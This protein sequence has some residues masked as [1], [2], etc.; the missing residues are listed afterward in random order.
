MGVFLDLCQ[1]PDFREVCTLLMGRGSLSYTSH[2]GATMSWQDFRSW[3][4]A[5]AR[6]LRSAPSQHE[7]LPNWPTRSRK[8][9][10]RVTR[11]RSAS[12]RRSGP[13]RFFSAASWAWCVSRSSAARWVRV[14]KPTFNNQERHIRTC[15]FP[16]VP[17]SLHRTR[18]PP[19]FGPS[20]RTPLKFITNFGTSL[21]LIC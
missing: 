13:V 19:P 18:Q 15:A 7:E 6:D 17:T 2:P 21:F 11:A 1:N 14:G 20:A 4:D 8:A 12:L 5:T 10:L 16:M 3:E 9:T